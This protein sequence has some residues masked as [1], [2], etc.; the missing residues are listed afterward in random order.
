LSI[1]VTKFDGSTAGE[2]FPWTGASVE[3]GGPAPAVDPEAPVVPEAPAATDVVL[4]L[5]DPHPLAITA[6]ST[7]SAIDATA[8]PR[9]P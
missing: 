3:A 6:T 2:Y 9:I 4:L 1:A 7:A 8:V 5:E